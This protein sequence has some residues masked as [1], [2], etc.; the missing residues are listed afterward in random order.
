MLERVSAD[1][2]MSLASR[3]HPP[4]LQVG[5]VLIFDV[6][7]GLDIGS[8]RAVLQQRIAAVPRLRQR[9]EKVPLGCG[10]P[11][12]VDDPGFNIDDHLTVI[13]EQSETD[14]AGLLDIAASLVTKPLPENRPLWTAAFVPALTGGRAALILVMH[15]VV[16]DGLAGLAVLRGLVDGSPTPRLAAFP[17]AAPEP[18]R[19]RKEM[20]GAT[21]SARCGDCR[22]RSAGSSPRSANSAR[23]WPNV[24]SPAP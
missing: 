16:G 10:R 22:R 24:P 4:P 12:W 11:V 23:R 2:L 6:R 13:E 18:G 15:H 19:A 8:L 9:L 17:Q 21:A 1:D 14:D 3:R 5:A 20:P 7:G